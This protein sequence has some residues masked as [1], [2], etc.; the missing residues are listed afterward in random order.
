[1]PNLADP[2]KMRLMKYTPSIALLR[3]LFAILTLLAGSTLAADHAN[4]SAIASA[5]SSNHE[6][7][8]SIIDFDNALEMHDLT[9]AATAGERVR[10]QRRKPDRL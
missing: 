8:R 7:N 5:K 3:I 10:L 9:S 4:D 2:K 1:M 6:I